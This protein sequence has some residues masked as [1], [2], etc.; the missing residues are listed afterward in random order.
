MTSERPKINWVLLGYTPQACKP[1][2][3]S[4]SKPKKEPGV[5][6]RG[7]RHQWFNG[8]WDLT[9][10]RQGSGATPHCVWQTSSRTWQQDL[11]HGGGAGAGH[12]GTVCVLSVIGGIDRSTVSYQGNQQRNMPL[13]A[14]LISYHSGDSS[15]LK[16]RTII[17]WG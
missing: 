7:Q 14:P 6:D 3:C 10:L 9:R 13:P 15:D 16:M 17:C 8:W 12:R 5:S 4:F 2:T 11:L 1:C